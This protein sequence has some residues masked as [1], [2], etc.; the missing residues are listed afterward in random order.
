MAVLEFTGALPRVRLYSNWLITTNDSEILSLLANGIFDPHQ[1]VIVANSIPQPP[2][3]A[4]TNT[5]PGEVKF[6]SYAPKLIRFHAECP[7]PSVLLHNDKHNPNW[8]VTVDGQPAELLRC[9]YLMRGVYLNPGSHEIEFR[10]EPSTKALKITLVAWV[11]CL[12]I[13]GFVIAVPPRQTEGRSEQNAR[14]SNP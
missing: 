10:Y 11:F 14:P 9:N 1:S 12:G 8:K 3:T 13:L 5:A 4:M 7:T 2:P 6:T